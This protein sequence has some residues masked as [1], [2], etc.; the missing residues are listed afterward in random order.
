MI[1]IISKG[2]TYQ[3]GRRREIGSVYCPAFGSILMR[4]AFSSC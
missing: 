3:E 4:N 1:I 2:R